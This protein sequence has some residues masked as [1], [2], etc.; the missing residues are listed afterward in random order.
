[1][2]LVESDLNGMALD[3]KTTSLLIERINTS[4]NLIE[5]HEWGVGLEIFLENVLEFQLPLKK[6]AFDLIREI[7]TASHMDFEEWDSLELLIKEI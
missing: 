3:R 7:F 5:N 2:S 4:K 6:H 1:M